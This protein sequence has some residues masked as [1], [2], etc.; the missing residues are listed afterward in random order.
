MVG[1]SWCDKHAISSPSSN[2]LCFGGDH[3]P[4]LREVKAARRMAGTPPASG[5]SSPTE[6][7]QPQQK[8]RGK[9]NAEG[10]AGEKGSGE[11][12]GDRTAILALR[13]T[14]LLWP[15]VAALGQEQCKH[16]RRDVQIE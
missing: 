13:E 14:V 12:G 9:I 3:G 16:R 1:S 10:A 7:S 4:E 6:A 8:D 15:S 5:R 2:H 11:R